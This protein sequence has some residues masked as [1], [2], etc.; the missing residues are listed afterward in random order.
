MHRSL[1]FYLLLL[2]GLPLQAQSSADNAISHFQKSYQELDFAAEDVADLRVTD[3]YRSPDGTEHVYLAQYYRGIPVFKSQAI[4]HYRSNRLVHKSVGLVSH[5]ANYSTNAA[6]ALSAQVAVYN[7]A[8]RIA[9]AFGRPLFTETL[10]GEDLFVWP[11]VSREAIRSQ[12]VYLPQEGALTLAWRVLIDR[13]D[14]EAGYYLLLLDATT[15]EL[16][17]KH[18]L[19]LSCSFGEPHEHDFGA[20]CEAAAPVVA[21]A[22]MT[23]PSLVDGATYNVFP[24][25]VESPIHGERQLEVSPA[26][27]TASPFGWHDVNGREGAEF[28]ITRGNNVYA[29]PDREEGPDNDNIA[30]SITADGGEELVFDYFFEQNQP[31]D[32]ILK[33]AITQS[34]YTS[35][36]LHDWLYVHGFDEPAGNFQFNNYGNGGAE[37]DEL[38]AQVQDGSGR[39]NANFFTPPDGFN[40][41]MQMMLW[42]APINILQVLAPAELTGSYRGGTAGFG[43]TIADN[44]PYEGD[45]VVALDS[46]EAPNLLCGGVANAAEV[47]G[48]IALVTR[49]AC[50]FEL[51][52]KNA[53]DAGAIGVIVCNNQAGILNMAGSGELG[54]TIP[55]VLISTADC[56]PI[57]EQIDAGVNVRVRLNA[58]PEPPIDSDFD[59]GV[60]AHEYGH[61]LSTRLVGGPNTGCLFN[62]EQMGE[63]WSDFL[64]VASTPA[65]NTPNPTGAEPRGIGNYAGS[66]PIDG[67]GIRSQPY[68]TDPN[69]NN[70]I[71]EDIIYSGFDGAPHPVGEPWAA[72]LLDIYW[73]YVNRDGLDPDLINGTGGNNQA[74]RL[75]IE[76]MKFTQCFP[77]MLDARD[78]ILAADEVVFGGVDQCA[79]WEIFAR[80]GMGW[81]ADQGSNEDRTDNRSAFDTSP[82]CTGAIEMNKFVDRPTVEA[83]EA[84]TFAIQAISYRDSAVQGVVIVDTL[85]AGMELDVTTIDGIDSFVVEGNRVTFEVGEMAAFDTVTVTYDATT[86]PDVSSQS[87]FFDGVEE[88]SL[89]NWSI[90]TTTESETWRPVRDSALAF[91]GGSAWFI[92]NDTLSQTQLLQVAAPVNLD[93]ARPA[94]RFFTRYDTEAARDFGWVQVGAA[95]DAFGLVRSG[96]LLRGDYRGRTAPNSRGGGLPAFWGASDGYEEIIVEL[97]TLRN[98]DAFFNF[99]F[100]SDVTG[101]NEGWYL[102]NVEVLD[103]VNYDPVATLTSA[104]GDTVLAAVGDLGVLVVS[105]DT[106]VNVTDP[107]LGQASVNVFPNPATDVAN[108]QIDAERGGQATLQVFSVDGKIVYRQSMQL[109]PG[110]NTTSVATDRLTSGLYTVQLLGADWVGTTKL[111]VQ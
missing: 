22:A 5:L 111:V 11:G 82:F 109:R 35:N 83:G 91:G 88:D 29:Y 69:I 12:L 25:G 15:G 75:V 65:T 89:D 61:G 107:V 48:K 7:A 13:F 1:L 43:P 55:S 59:L 95:S 49:G 76:G 39:N 52:V 70:K 21:T 4:L 58:E 100:V 8:Q 94:L 20:A 80:R 17:D 40:P 86:S 44:G 71:Y 110:L 47:N 23:P 93:A 33:A 72:V 81:S 45:I 102:D 101:A 24:F 18:N 105:A 26:D 38:S 77:G 46:T 92:P 104:A 42:D 34:F 66:A 53:Q 27:A 51:K 84:V 37:G 19:V 3:A 41:R 14:E 87:L 103:V 2:A 64:A 79:L 99:L 96:S 68:S 54:V 74:M 67:R 16:L 28:F 90:V 10:H 57:R 32:T 50:A 73:F 63:G 62:D 106:T 31:V 56:D 85:P 78:G 6:P 60:V 30:D 97:D 108:V 9:P 36:K 98:A